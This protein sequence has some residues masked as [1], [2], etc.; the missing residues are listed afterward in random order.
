MAS[1]SAS[2]GGGVWTVSLIEAINELLDKQE[3]ATVERLLSLTHARVVAWARGNGKSQ[4]P[5]YRRDAA[6]SA[7]LLSSPRA[8]S[9]AAPPDPLSELVINFQVRI[10]Q[11]G[12]PARLEAADGGWNRDLASVHLVRFTPQ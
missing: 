10:L 6:N 4:V 1:E 3:P 11:R 7:L 2:L 8:H 5:F 12:N 9:T